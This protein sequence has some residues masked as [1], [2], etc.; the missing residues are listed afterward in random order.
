MKN[1]LKA[2][3]I[4]GAVCG[5]PG[6]GDDHCRGEVRVSGEYLTTQAAALDHCNKP[7]NSN[8]IL[9]CADI[10]YDCQPVLMRCSEVASRIHQVAEDGL[11]ECVAQRDDS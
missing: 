1:I 5:T 11:V 9:T 10:E 7:E 4:A 8:D 2:A 6:C 3:L